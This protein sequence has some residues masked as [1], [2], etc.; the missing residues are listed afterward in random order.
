MWVKKD[1]RADKGRTDSCAWGRGVFRYNLLMKRTRQ[2]IQIYV[3]ISM[4]AQPGGRTHVCQA[5]AFDR[6][7]LNVL[8]LF[9]T[10]SRQSRDG[11]TSTRTAH[12][13]ITSMTTTAT[14]TTT[15]LTMKNRSRSPRTFWMSPRRCGLTVTPGLLLWGLYLNTIEW[16]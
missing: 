15:S 6:S 12:F 9:V 16:E 5:Q 4:Q 7:T 14:L 10:L 13:V 3:H 8:C 1:F 11:V 2:Q